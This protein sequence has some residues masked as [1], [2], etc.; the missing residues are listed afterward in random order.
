MVGLF[1]WNRVVKN[2]QVDKKIDKRPHREGSFS[3]GKFNETRLLLWRANRNAGWQHAEK[4]WCQGHWERCL[5]TCRKIQ[6]SSSS[7]VPSRGGSDHNLIR[8]SF[9]PSE[10]RTWTTSPLVQPFLLQKR[11]NQSRCCLSNYPQ[12][13]SELWYVCTSFAVGINCDIVQHYLIHCMTIQRNTENV[14]LP[15]RLHFH[16]EY[17]HIWMDWEKR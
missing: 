9:G 6:M 4:S 5:E 2:E 3:L 17:S 1:S 16:T 7:R 12:Q 10:C 14:D 8:S 11:L 13:K 15:R